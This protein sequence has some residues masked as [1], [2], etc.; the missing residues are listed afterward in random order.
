MIFGQNCSMIGYE[1]TI[2]DHQAFSFNIGRFSIPLSLDMINNDSIKNVTSD[3]NPKGVHSSG[4]YRFYL[5]KGNKHNYPGVYISDLMSCIMPT[6]LI[7]S[8]Q[9]NNAKKNC[10]NREEIHYTAGHTIYI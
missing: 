2:G 3:I 9:L 8:F 6:A 5:L 10:E 1:R 7:S 4:D